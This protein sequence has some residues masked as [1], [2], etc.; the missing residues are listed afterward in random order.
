[1]ALRGLGVRKN[2]QTAQFFLKHAAEQGGVV[3][4]LMSTALAAHD[5]GSMQRA[6][7]T[8]ALALTLTLTLTLG[9]GLGFGC[10]FGFAFA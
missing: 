5:A 1:M 9:F 7:V 4:S 10:G 3:R 6:S 2:C 8:L